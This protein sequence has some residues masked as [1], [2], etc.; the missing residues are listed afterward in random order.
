ME[1]EITDDQIREKAYLL[2][3][4]DGAMEGCADEYWRE[5]RRAI[6]IKTAQRSAEQSAEQSDESQSA[7][8]AGRPSAS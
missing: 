6:E 4:A 1:I 5:A 2:W 3:L 7:S 8:E